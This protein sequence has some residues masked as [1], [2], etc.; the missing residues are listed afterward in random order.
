[1]NTSNMF[2]C[3]YPLSLLCCDVPVLERIE[4]KSIE[5][6]CCGDASILLL[7]IDGK[8]FSVNL[9]ESSVPR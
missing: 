4:C 5:V 1:M 8:V 7:S 3:F 2:H 6:V 9:K